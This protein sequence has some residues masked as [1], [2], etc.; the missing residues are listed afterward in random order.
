M[1]TKKIDWNRFRTD[2]E[3][4]GEWRILRAKIRH[5]VDRTCALAENATCSL[6]DFDAIR[7]LRMFAL[8]YVDGR[9][10]RLPPSWLVSAV[11]RLCDLDPADVYARA[12]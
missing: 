1:Q 2:R 11:A 4:A 10:P 6:E 8:D 9:P 3:L 5:V 12:A 7:T